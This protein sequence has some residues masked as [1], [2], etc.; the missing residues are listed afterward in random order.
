MLIVDWPCTRTPVPVCMMNEYIQ[1]TK[2][3]DD[4]QS[5][6]TKQAYQTTLAIDRY[7]KYLNI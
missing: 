2:N 4:T 3:R 7:L 5:T 1:R 6:S